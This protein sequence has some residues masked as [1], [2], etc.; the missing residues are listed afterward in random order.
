M[1]SFTKKAIMETFL[2]L[3]EK[4]PL[5]KITVRDLVDKCGINRNTFYYYFQDIYAVLEEYC[6]FAM[7]SLAQEKS[8]QAL[9]C[10]LLRLSERFVKARPK[11]AKML[12]LSLGYEGLERYFGT[13]F[14]PILK[15]C[16]TQCTGNAPSTTMLRFLRHAVLGLCLDTMRAERHAP[17]TDD[18]LEQIFQALFR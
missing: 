9:L 5:E 6:D 18:E 16:I 15:D 8:P 3:T 13:R 1:P 14:E 2:C 12:A 4:K 11:A 17:Y 10:G 7:E